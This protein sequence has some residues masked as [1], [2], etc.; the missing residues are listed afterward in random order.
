MTLQP[1]DF[2]SFGEWLLRPE[3]FLESAL[4]QGIVL[5]VLAVLLGLI[6]A[7]LVSAV[8]HGPGEGF[9]AVARS[10]RDL[11]RSDLPGTSSR[12]IFALAKLAYQEALRRRV[13]VVV[14]LFVVGLLFAGWYLDPRSS[15]PA[16]LYIS[17]VLT[18]TNYLILL[19]ALFIST[20]SLPA[21]IKNRTIYTIVTKPVRATEIVLGRMLGFVAV[22]TLMLVPMGIAS[23]FFVT[24]GLRHDHEV[25][26]IDEVGDGRFEGKLSFDQ[27]HDHSFTIEPSADPDG[28][29]LGL[30]DTVRGHRH[31]VRQYRDAEG[32]VER[33]EIGEPYGALR[34]R[35]PVYGSLVFTDRAG[36]LTDE[37][38]DV[39]NE[40]ARG[41]YGA[42]GIARLV[43]VTREAQRLD[44][45]YVEGGTLG[46]AIYTFNGVTPRRFTDEEG[47]PMEM[48]LRAFR[49]IKGDIVS[50]LNGSIT[51]RNPDKPQIESNPLTFVVQEYDV[52]EERLPR[53]IEG[54]DG[55]VTRK[56]SLF[57]DLVT[58]DGRLE[59]IIRCIDRQQYLGMTTSAVY[60]RPAES[61]FA[62]NLTKSY[63][64]IWLQMV[65]VIAFGV[66]FSTF[67]SG[68]VAMV[69][70]FAC[71]LL[72]FTAEQIYDIRYYMDRGESMGGGPVE[73]LVRL[74][75]QDS[76][77]TELDVDQV[78]G[79]VIQGVDAVIIYSLD[80]VA[81]SLPNLPRMLSTAE[82]A[83]SGF[84]I[85]GALL[86]RHAV[87]T[88]GYVLLAFLI[89]YF[90]LKTREIAA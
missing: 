16:R 10:V 11:V 3:S 46:S 28:P 47:I 24:R 7:Y 42:A 71:V 2:W 64:S 79:K 33:H 78:A 89:G 80:A 15:D 74:L 58:D 52:S 54:T 63:L 51:L 12:R 57:D 34:A 43:G 30:T 82:Y 13:L 9:Y 61:S 49:T 55:E 45:G 38:I 25:V 50:G 59:V 31:V 41:G 77:T 40:K 62:W 69:A 72:G 8:R 19:L 67:L 21:D 81:T 68:P 39:G 90:F 20:F 23:Y 18:A 88:F 65:M 1:E 36:N 4:L 27:F 37:G 70:T 83:A 5:V 76:M 75:R 56:L 66:M 35:V 48:A 44:Y 26:E 6:I 73:S 84:D 86:A 53:E 22:G 32:N 14:G 60:L 29:E 87:A 85:F 17:F